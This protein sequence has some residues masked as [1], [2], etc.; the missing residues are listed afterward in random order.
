M[1]FRLFARAPRTTIDA[2]EPRP[3]PSLEIEPALLLEV[4]AGEALRRFHDFRGRALGDDLAAA[5]SRSRPEID[6]VV[7]R[8]YR[9]AVVLDDDD[10][11]PGV[12]ELLQRRDEPLVVAVVEPDRRLVEDV[13]NADELRADLRGEPYPLRFAARERSG[14]A[15][16]REVREPDVREK[17]E[18]RARSP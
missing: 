11:V 14:R 17:T 15:I 18:P 7:G 8:E 12:P 13:E 6:H 1:L 2:P 4:A 3:A 5:L 16:E 10:G 9:V